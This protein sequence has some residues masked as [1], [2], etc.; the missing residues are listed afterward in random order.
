M[1]TDYRFIP[2][3]N[4]RDFPFLT[5]FVEEKISIDLTTPNHEMGGE[6]MNLCWRNVEDQENW[7]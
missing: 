1:R 2:S 7:L 6:N 3:S 4:W 5:H